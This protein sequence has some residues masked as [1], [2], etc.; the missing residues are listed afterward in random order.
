MSSG[1][2]LAISTALH[3]TSLMELSEL[4]FVE[5]DAILLPTNTLK[6]V[7]KSSYL[8]IVS[9]LPNL[10]VSDTPLLLDKT[11]SAAVAPCFM[12]VSMSRFI[13]SVSLSF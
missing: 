9:S 4:S 13:M 3:A 2:I 11:Q 5:T 10:L 7:S 1:A 8:S 6:P 12:A